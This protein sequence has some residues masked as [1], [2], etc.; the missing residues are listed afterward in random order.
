MGSSRSRTARI[1]RVR[2][3]EQLPMW[4]SCSVCYNHPSAMS[5][6]MTCRSITFAFL[7]RGALQG[8]RI[9]IDQ[10]YFK[11]A[12]GGEDDIIAVVNTALQTMES[13]GA[14]L[15]L[16]DS[17]DS[18]AYF[19]A[20]FT[21][22]L[23]E[24]KVQIA[25]YLAGLEHTD[26]HTL[27]DLIAFDLANCA[28]E[29]K[30]FGQEVFE[31]SEATS[32]NLND[33][34]YIEARALCLQLSRD[35]GIDAALQRDNLD[36]LVAPSYSFASTPAAV[37]GYPNISVPVGITVRGKPAGIWMYSTFLHEPEL[38]AFAYDLE[39]EIQPRTQPAFLGKVPPEPP[40][41]GLCNLVGPQSLMS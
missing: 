4:L 8:A 21:V 10:R 40:D 25:D 32:G 28:E 38:L 29:M 11:P 2:C 6:V 18:N 39:Q 5:L 41:A 24:F 17:G 15:V 33:P 37:A 19:D 26:A 7:R 1:R 34:E 9:G 13:L 3:A 27:A 30:Y 12:Y 31:M 35:E 14:T 36:A 20:E 23:Y 22:L 16:T